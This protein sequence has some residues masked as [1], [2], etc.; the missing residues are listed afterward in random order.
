MSDAYISLPVAF[1]FNRSNRHTNN[2]LGARIGKQEVRAKP[3]RSAGLTPRTVHQEMPVFFEHSGPIHTGRGAP[4]NRR[5]Q[6]LEHIMVNGSVHTGCNVLQ[7]LSLRPLLWNYLKAHGSGEEV[8][9]G[10]ANKQQ[11]CDLQ[12]RS[13]SLSSRK[14]LAPSR[15]R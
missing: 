2:P 15:A 3:K 13:L 9:R 8:R 1:K 4:R 10:H 11:K 7:K 14:R 5:T 6:I 12:M